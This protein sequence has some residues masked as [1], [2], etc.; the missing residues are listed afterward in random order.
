MNSGAVEHRRVVVGRNH[1]RGWKQ[2]AMASKGPAKDILRTVG[3]G[4][5][6]TARS[7][8]IAHANAAASALPTPAVITA[9]RD[10]AKNLHEQ[11]HAI[12]RAG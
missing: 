9:T 5:G 7:A 11:F 4:I 10:V 8:C 1:C 6:E 2:R 3:A 12:V